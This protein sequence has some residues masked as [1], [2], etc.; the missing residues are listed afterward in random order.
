MD[1]TPAITFTANTRRHNAGWINSTHRGDQQVRLGRLVAQWV[2][3]TYG[4]S[5]LLA[6][7]T[8]LSPRGQLR[9][10]PGDPA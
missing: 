2:N 9:L 5:A 7:G 3:R 10:S 1:R 4:V 6:V 8:E